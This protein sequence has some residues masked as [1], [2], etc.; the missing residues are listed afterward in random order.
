M[1]YIPG[2]SSS[3]IILCYGEIV[4]IILDVE[5]HFWTFTVQVPCAKSDQIGDFRGITEGLW[6]NIMEKTLKRVMKKDSKLN[7]S[8]LG[9]NM[10]GF[11]TSSNFRKL[12]S[13]RIRWCTIVEFVTNPVLFFSIEKGNC[14]SGVGFQ[15][16]GLSSQSSDKKY[17]LMLPISWVCTHI[18]HTKLV[19]QKYSAL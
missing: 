1:S 8:K 2:C 7:H 15:R 3:L 17:S 19:Q 9:P 13:Y 12:S 6:F 10:S 14:Y 4:W 16:L 5:K 18:L 11:G